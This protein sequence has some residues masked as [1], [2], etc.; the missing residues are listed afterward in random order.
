MA[1]K[2]K[3]ALTLNPQKA[4]KGLAWVCYGGCGYDVKADRDGCCAQCGAECNI[5]NKKKCYVSWQ[6]RQ[7]IP[8]GW[9]N[10]GD[11][12]SE[13]LGRRALNIA[14]HSY[15]ARLYRIEAYPVP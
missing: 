7:I 14:L 5:E 12:T 3:A 4:G 6:V 11:Y 8:G 15:P 9:N 13:K 1:T 10:L 2:K